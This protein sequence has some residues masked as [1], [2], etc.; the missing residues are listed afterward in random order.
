MARPAPE[1]DIADAAFV[2][3]ILAEAMNLPVRHR[4]AEDRGDG[5]ENGIGVEPVKTRRGIPSGEHDD[6]TEDENACSLHLQEA[7]HL[8][9]V[10]RPP[11]L[12]E[13][14]I[15]R[16]VVAL[17]RAPQDMA[18]EARRPSRRYGAHHQLPR[19]P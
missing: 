18:A 11:I 12:L 19:R 6:D 15:A 10:T 17:Q 1:A 9:A 16:I 5:K 8:P 14:R 4:L 7:E 3:R 13:L 2:G